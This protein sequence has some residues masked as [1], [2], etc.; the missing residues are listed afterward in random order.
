MCYFSDCCYSLECCFSD[1]L[2]SLYLLI[3]SLNLYLFA[4]SPTS[5]FD[6]A[7]MCYSE[8]VGSMIG[9]SNAGFKKF[10]LHAAHSMWAIEICSMVATY[11]CSMNLEAMVVFPVD[12]TIFVE[13]PQPKAVLPQVVS[14]SHTMAILLVPFPKYPSSH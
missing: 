1:Y 7:I 5:R 11:L 4:V 9:F 13:I 3:S 8:D 6:A 12:S 2:T 10:H 14:Y